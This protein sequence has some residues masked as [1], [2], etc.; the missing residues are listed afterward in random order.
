MAKPLKSILKAIGMGSYD[1]PEVKE[2]EV[3]PVAD[4]QARKRKLMRAAGAKGGLG[5]VGSNMSGG[6]RGLG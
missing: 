6:D 2:P 5:R 3:L 1:A 4:D